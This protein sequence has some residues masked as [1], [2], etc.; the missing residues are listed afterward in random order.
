MTLQNARITG[1]KLCLPYDII[2]YKEYFLT[3]D[4]EKSDI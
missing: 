1:K 2:D 3:V 4:F